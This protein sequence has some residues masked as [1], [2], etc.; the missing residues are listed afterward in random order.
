MAAPES[1]GRDSPLARRMRRLREVAGFET[2]TAFAAFLGV[3]PQRW[4][5]VEIGVPLGNQMAFI[6]VQKIPGL[7]LD[8]LY[9]G[10]PDGLP[11]A[12][13]RK[14]EEPEPSRTSNTGR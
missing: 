2:G 5:N 11:L 9:F 13:A 3:S 1:H 8:W 7:T 14:L 10:K 6:L 4:N 12:L